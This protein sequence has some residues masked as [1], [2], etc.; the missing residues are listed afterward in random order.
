MSRLDDA[1][2]AH[3][4][5]VVREPDLS[6]TRYQL[7]GIA[8]SGGMGT[9]YAVQ[10]TALDRRVAMKVLDLP[11]GE[12]EARLRREATVLARLEHPGVVPVHDVGRLADGRAYYTMKLVEGERLD[13]Y[14]ARGPPL[15]ER[16]R[17]LLRIAD[18]VAFAH[19]RAVLHRDLKPQNVMIGAFGQVLVLDWGLAKVLSEAGSRPEPLEVTRRPMR[20][21]TGEGAVLGT[22]GFMAPEQERGGSEAVDARADVYSLGAMLKWLAG[23]SAPPAVQAIARK[24]MS[25]QPDDRYGT[26]AELAGD[27]ERFLDGGAVGAY[28][29]GL[30]RRA[31]RVARRHR[32]AIGIVL[33]YLVGR[34]LILLFAHGRAS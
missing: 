17:V 21:D 1:A 16:L 33:A 25:A 28:P 15:N 8:G 34:A 3:L 9:V 26:A 18:A 4:Q 11:D 2:I 19:S 13:G 23:E 30:V 29:E 32:V 7:V 27:V 6:G 10:D 31:V 5:S 24:A 14:A 12:L 22:P 20:G